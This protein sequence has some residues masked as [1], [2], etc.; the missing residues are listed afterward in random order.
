VNIVPVHFKNNRL[1][2]VLAQL[3]GFDPIGADMMLL[4]V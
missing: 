4:H 2:V 1:N 3:D